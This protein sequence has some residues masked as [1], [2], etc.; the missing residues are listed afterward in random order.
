[1]FLIHK[2]CYYCPEILYP[3]EK[4]NLCMN[5]HLFTMLTCICCATA[6]LQAQQ[7]ETAAPYYHSLRRS[8]ATPDRDLQPNTSGQSG[9]G[10]NY[11]VKYHKI[12]WRINPDS[13]VKYIRGWVQT[14]F[15][16]I[17]AS[18]AS[19]TFDINAVLT[20]DSV[21]F[22]GARLAAGNITRAG[23]IMT[24]ALGATLANGTLDSIWVYY[25]GTPPAVSGAAEGYQVGTDATTAQKYIYTLSESY[26]DRDWW[27]CKAD[28]QDKID[29][30]DITVSAPWTGA[31]TFWVATN[32]KLVDSAI[33]GSSRLFT[34]KNRY[35]MASYLVCVAVARFNRYYYPKVTVGGVAIPV[36]FYLHRGKSAANYTAILN[37]MNTQTQV[38]SAFSTRFGDYPFKYEK[39]GYYDGLGGAGGMEHQTFRL[40][41]VAQ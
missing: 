33:S 39:H 27:P 11:D 26:E 16:T 23:N 8:P 20:V 21:R 17:V 7:T 15:K 10:A 5:K 18:V 38:L 19:I 25:R 24:I 40:C 9:T 31:D 2:S 32:G 29:S 12:F 1:L 30:I 13:S 34:Y 35:P 28:M 22:R 6:V 36:V 41:R 14:N 4:I 3:Q 37:A